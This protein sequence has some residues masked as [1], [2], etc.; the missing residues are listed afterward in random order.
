MPAK[1]IG[2]REFAKLAGVQYTA[3]RKYHYRSQVR[4]REVAEGKAK[5]VAA[6]MLP[7][8]D[9]VIGL[10]PAWYE[11]TAKQWIE[12]RPRAGSGPRA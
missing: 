7:E 4:R 10:S 6:W 12:S 3:M 2:L 5:K 8:P 1:L 9:A 11:S